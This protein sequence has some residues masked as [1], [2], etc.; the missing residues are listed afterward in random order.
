MKIDLS[1]QEGYN[2][3]AAVRG[4]DFLANRLKYIVTGRIRYLAGVSCGT[5]R[6]YRLEFGRDDGVCRLGLRKTVDEIMFMIAPRTSDMHHYLGHCESALLA[7]GYDHSNSSLLRFVTE[8]S[9]QCRPSPSAKR[10]EGILRRLEKEE[11]K[12]RWEQPPM[13]LP[14]EV[15]TTKTPIIIPAHKLQKLLRIFNRNDPPNSD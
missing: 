3:A 2:I 8:L 15:S 7:L 10:I 6:R 1:T 9:V 4:P 14:T 12:E 5:E 13:F 11:G